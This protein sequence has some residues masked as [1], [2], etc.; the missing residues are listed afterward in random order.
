MTLPNF[1]VIGA[2]R[3]GTTSLHHYLG[4]H[5]EVYLPHAKAPSYF[6]CCDAPR[7]DDPYLHLVS[8]NYFVR[9]FEEY[10]ALFD[11]VRSETAI[12]EVSPVYLATTQ[13]APRIAEL[14]P[15]VK[16][17]AVIRN[18]VDRA[19]ARFL[20]RTRDGLERRTSFSDIVREEKDQGLLRDDAHGTYVASGFVFHFLESY[21]E[22]FRREAF[23]VRLFEDLKSD[24]EG[25]VAEAFEFLGVDS[26]FRPALERHYNPS[27]GVIR[28]PWLRSIWSNTGL[29]RARLRPL[30]PVAIRDAALASLPM[31][32]TDRSLDPQIR[33]ELVELFRDDVSRLQD[34]LDR[35]LSAWLQV[36]PK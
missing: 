13:A 22:H 28:Q 35:D 9:D 24:A 29:L 26:A 14:I 11:E 36:A 15:A 16:L 18:P 33:S 2:G 4:Q 19:W 23:F 3:S 10:Q 12:G 34:W 6:Y 8:R 5:P 32:H 30:L 1:L 27:R 21:L 31:D 25:L 17:L 20:G 7:S